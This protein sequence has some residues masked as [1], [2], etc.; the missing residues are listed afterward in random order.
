MTPNTP[1]SRPRVGCL[2]PPGRKG[3]GG[4]K[5]EGSVRR[6]GKEGALGVKQGAEEGEWPIPARQRPLTTNGV[7][8]T[9]GVAIVLLR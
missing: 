6:R 1:S 9:E 8:L 5:G 7:A 2:G 4:E 3:E